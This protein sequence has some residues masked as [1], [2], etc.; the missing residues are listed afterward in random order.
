[1]RRKKKNGG[2]GSANDGGCGS[3]RGGGT[4]SGGRCT[5]SPLAYKALR[6]P[7]LFLSRAQ[8]PSIEEEAEEEE[9]LV[10]PQDV[11]KEK[12]SEVSKCSKLKDVYETCNERVNSRTKT[13]EECTEELFDFL[14][15][16]DKCVSQHNR[17]DVCTMWV[18][19]VNGAF[20]KSN[21][22]SSVP[23][24]YCQQLTVV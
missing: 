5:S 12:C 15:C 17:V 13:T 3:G 1:M 2:R 7:L 23:R 10:D 9:D 20:Y 6:M 18:I 24:Q 16:V 11:L 21:R 8:E 4:A 14:H 19:L 22:R